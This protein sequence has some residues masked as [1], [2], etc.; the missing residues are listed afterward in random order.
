[1]YLQPTL[2]VADDDPDH[3]GLLTTWL[4]HYGYRVM[5][6]D[7]GDN[8]VD[9]AS[10][11][12]RRGD[13]FLLDLEMPGRDGLASCRELRGMAGYAR[14]PALLVSG[15][16]VEGLAERAADAGVTRIIPKD[17]EMLRNLRSWLAANLPPAQ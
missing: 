6:F 12:T 4:E 1:M 10:G 9:W 7:S 8:L 15:A 13:A 2:V 14:T 5:S 11:S 16:R 17:D 3:C